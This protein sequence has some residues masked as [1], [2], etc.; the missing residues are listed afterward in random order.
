MR[1]FAWVGLFAVA[2]VFTPQDAFSMLNLA[3]TLVLLYEASI[4]SLVL[5]EGWWT[6]VPG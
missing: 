4:P 3:I 6:T 1:R 2:A 5:M